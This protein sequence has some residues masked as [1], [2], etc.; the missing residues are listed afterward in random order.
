M[1][2]KFLLTNMLLVFALSACG[3]NIELI[4]PIETSVLTLPA[5]STSIS[6]PTETFT[7]TMQPPTETIT[8][9]PEPT[10]I[11]FE[12]ENGESLE[13][14]MFQTTEKAFE[15]IMNVDG[16]IKNVIFGP[17]DGAAFFKT[18]FKIK[19][20][21]EEVMSGVPVSILGTNDYVRVMVYSTDNGT[22]LA[23]LDKDRSFKSIFVNQKAFEI[24]AVLTSG[25]Y[26]I[27]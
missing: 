5:I 6:L 7:P 25:Q 23:Y 20:L 17:N 18:L 4:Q 2:Y 15:H 13:M 8:S 11:V 9:T 3:N 1:I 27:P 16:A 21:G 22:I 10:A 12:L 26:A 19:G 24:H 14:P